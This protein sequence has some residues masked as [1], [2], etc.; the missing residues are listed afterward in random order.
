MANAMFVDAKIAF[1]QATLDLDNDIRV[2]LGDAA[3]DDPNVTTDNFLDDIAAGARVA[4]SDALASKTFTSATFDAADKT[5]TAVTGDVS[6]WIV[7]YY[8]SG[9]EATAQ[10]IWKM[11]TGTGLPVTPNGGNITAQWNA[12]GIITWSG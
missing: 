1:F 3:D 6:E 5:W 11:D 2:I 12:S 4:V 10:L 9:S 7:G 8:H